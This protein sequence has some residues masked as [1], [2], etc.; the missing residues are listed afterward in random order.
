[1]PRPLR[2]CEPG[3]T[4]HVISRCVES[5]N[6]M[7]T[8][9]YKDLM[10]SIIDKAL[11]KYSFELIAYEILDNHFHFIIKTLHGG[12]NISRIMQ[13]IKSRFAESYNRLNKREGAFWSERFKSMIIE[14]SKNPVKYLFWL[15]WYLGFN[16]VRKKI[17]KDPRKYKYGSINSYIDETYESPL[18]ITQHEYFLQLGST[19]KERVRRFLYYE[20][21]Y[22]KR[23][24]FI[25]DIL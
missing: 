17:V 15:L 20:E 16:S 25:F 11:N 23:L 24:S 10:V 3:M 6:M 1:M 18:K 7:N 12:E 22:R 9:F 19:F 2:T 8:D 4:Y 5:R 13:Y 14:L 21:A